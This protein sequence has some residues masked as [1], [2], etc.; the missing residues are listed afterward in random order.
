M[1]LLYISNPWEGGKK[2]Q[3]DCFIMSITFVLFPLTKRR[4]IR[5]L[6]PGPYPD[7]QKD[8]AN[9]YECLILFIYCPCVKFNVN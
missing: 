6:R 7:F 5:S 2:E 3:I 9:S 4:D 1:K 8:M